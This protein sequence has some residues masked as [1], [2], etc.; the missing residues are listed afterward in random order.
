MDLITNSPGL[1]HLADEIFKHLNY[2]DLEKCAQVNESWKIICENPYLLLSSCIFNGYLK[3]NKS[4]WK[5][6][7][8]QIIRDADQKNLEIMK[9]V[10]KM[11][12]HHNKHGKC[13]KLFC[14]FCYCIGTMDEHHFKWQQLGDI[15]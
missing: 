11:I 7:I 13:V 3:D 9:N 5:Q 2:I 14:V 8:F 4:A 10:L 15:L 12:L 1:Q 6:K